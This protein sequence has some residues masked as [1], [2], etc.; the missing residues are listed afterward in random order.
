MR[1]RFDEKL[2]FFEVPW[3]IGVNEEDKDSLSMA[4]PYSCGH[5]SNRRLDR[6]SIAAWGL[7]Q[8]FRIRKKSLVSTA[9]Q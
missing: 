4:K 1:D 3:S 6:V 8:F 5:A 2:S 9:L 7:K